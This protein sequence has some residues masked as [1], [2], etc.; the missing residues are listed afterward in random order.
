MKM[1]RKKNI[2]YTKNGIKDFVKKDIIRSLNNEKFVILRGYFHKLEVKKVL[3][4]I[5]NKFH[6][7]NDKIRPTSKYDL[8]KSNY[9]RFMFGM[10]GGLKKTNPRYFRVFY[11]PIWSKDIY[12]GRNLF[13]KLNK[14]QNYFY[15]LDEDYGV[16]NSKKPTRHRLFVASRF[17]HYPSG[18]GYLAPHIDEGA[19]RASKELKLKLHYNLLLVM[20]EKGK[21]Y[22]SGGGF[23]INNGNMVNVDDYTKIGD[24]VLYSSKTVHGVLDVD[25]KYFPDLNSTNGRYVALTTLFKW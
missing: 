11:N 23:V 13:L 21:D 15:G 6:H 2:F 25:P 7:R 10:T 9:Q 3:T 17:Q 5:K 1:Q 8:I 16:M 22:K 20:T 14:L 4:N 12:K 18:G 19:I 24:V